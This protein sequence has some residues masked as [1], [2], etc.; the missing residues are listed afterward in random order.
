VFLPLVRYRHGRGDTR[1]VG[2]DTE[3][4]IDGFQR[5]ANTFAVVAFELAQRRR[6]VVA[7]HVHAPAQIHEAVRLQ[8]PTIVLI[9]TPE[10]CTLSNLIRKQH[11]TPKLILTSWIR[12]YESL[13]PVR[14]RVVTARFGAVTADYGSVIGRV[15]RTFGTDFEEF[16]HTDANVATCFELIDRA[17]R[18]RNGSLVESA[19]ARPSEG[20][21]NLK[22]VLRAELETPALKGL[23][24]GAL[25][26]YR[27]WTASDD[28]SA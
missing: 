9:R 22:E 16:E 25:A 12:F 17:N 4:V 2:P 6:V 20:R 28:P 24:A 21:E 23:R 26:V 10:A 7:H 1:V 13:L 8:V 14:G 27:A 18:E 19:V 11:L 15:N 3:L 5:S